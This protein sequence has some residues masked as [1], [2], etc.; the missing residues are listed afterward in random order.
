MILLEKLDTEFGKRQTI[1]Q[2]SAAW[3]YLSY[4]GDSEETG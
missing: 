4:A 1:P 3:Q 2:R